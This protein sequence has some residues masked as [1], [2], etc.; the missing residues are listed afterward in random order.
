MRLKRYYSAW[1]RYHKSNGF[2]IHSPFAFKFVLNVLR[3][4]LPYYAYEDIHSLRHSVIEVTRHHG[5]HPRIISFKNAKLMFRVVNYFHPHHILQ[6]GTSYGIS[7]FSMLAVATDIHLHLYEPNLS[8]SQVAGQVLQSFA[9]RVTSYGTP[10]S[11]IA[12]YHATPHSASPFIVVNSLDDR[13]FA[14][15]MQYLSEVC[16]SE[17]VIIIRNISRSATM[18]RLWEECKVSASTGMTFSNDK[19]AVIVASSKL[20]HQDFFLWF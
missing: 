2:G 20:P 12:A 6:I 17:G 4:R 16:R 11:A 14:T 15:V 5:R 18:R 10:H 1:S 13:C 19:L 7:S 8:D 3:E 9:S